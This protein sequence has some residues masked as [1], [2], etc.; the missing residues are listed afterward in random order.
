[1]LELGTGDML[2]QEICQILVCGN[3]GDG[4]ISLLDVVVD[5]CMLDGNMLQSFWP[6]E[7]WLVNDGDSQLIIVQN[8]YRLIEHES[9]CW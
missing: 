8:T 2:G 7:Y 6:H 9:E 1:M 4:D 3:V 5:E